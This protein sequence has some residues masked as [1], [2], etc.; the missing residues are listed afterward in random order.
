MASLIRTGLVM[1]SRLAKTLATASRTSLLHARLIA[2]AMEQM[3]ANAPVPTARD[4]PAL[5]KHQVDPREAERMAA[6]AARGLA[7]LL[8]LLHELLAEL[9]EGLSSTAARAYLEGITASGKTAKLIRAI[10]SLPRQSDV[11]S[12]RHV[13]AQALAGRIERAE[14]WASWRAANAFAETMRVNV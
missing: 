9:G 3:L 13:A 10:L 7:A 4:L 12:R 5:L 2:S 8:E 6:S 11:A 14:R 1:P